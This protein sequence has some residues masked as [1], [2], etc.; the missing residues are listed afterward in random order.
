MVHN[1]QIK[2]MA[3]LGYKKGESTLYKF[4]FISPLAKELA[5]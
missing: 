3:Y 2:K 4:S 5:E 1:T